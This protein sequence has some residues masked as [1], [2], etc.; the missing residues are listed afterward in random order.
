MPRL[1]LAVDV[2]FVAEPAH[3]PVGGNDSILAVFDS[4][5]VQHFGQAAFGVVQVVR[6]NAVAPLVAVGQQPIG[7]TAKDPFIGGADVKHLTG[8]PVEGP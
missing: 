2:A 5:L 3:L 8:F 6:V 4:A 1:G 7:R